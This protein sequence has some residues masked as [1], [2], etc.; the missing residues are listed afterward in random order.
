MPDE[1]SFKCPRGLEAFVMHIVGKVKLWLVCFNEALARRREKRY[2]PVSESDYPIKNQRYK[3]FENR[4]GC[5][6]PGFV[7]PNYLTWIRT[8]ICLVFFLLA[9]ELSY[10][11]LLSMTIIGGL[12]DFFDGALARAQGKK[13]KLGVMLDP[14]AD[15]L[16]VFAVLY[17]L[18][19]RGDL[20]PAYIVCMALCEIHVLVIPMLSYGYQWKKGGDYRASA[21][22]RDRIQPVSFGR[23][24]LHFYVYAVLLVMAGRMIGS[25]SV[26]GVGNWFLI[27]GISAALIALFQYIFRWVKNPY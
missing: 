22:A 5:I 4:I 15:K 7:E 12:S 16:L 10:L 11:A 21:E 17:T 13:T 19:I 1:S 9:R 20:Q 27:L 2:L 14:L 24:K 23:V 3:A 26:A 18:T 8:V 6:F 25:A